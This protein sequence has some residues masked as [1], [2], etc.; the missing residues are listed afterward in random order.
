MPSNLIPYNK[1]QMGSLPGSEKLYLDGE[2]KKIQQTLQ[3]L[4]N[5][6][7]NPWTAYTPIITAGTGSVTSAT[8]SGS[9]TQVGR[10]VF[11]SQTCTITTIGSAGAWIGLSL[12]V[13]A[14]PGYYQ[15]NGREN[16]F[17]GKMLLGEISSGS[18]RSLIQ[19]YDGTAAFGNGSILQLSGVYE[20]A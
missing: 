9:Y 11:L 20:A 15:L 10:L 4:Q 8:S 17:T 16:A 3:A 6:L 7:G 19:F 1:A 14:G 12:P 18:T 2:L 5:D 13:A